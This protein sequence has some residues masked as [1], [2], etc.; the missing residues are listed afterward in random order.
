MQ[1]HRVK[2]G[3]DTLHGINAPEPIQQQRFAALDTKASPT[4]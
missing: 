1:R 4:R 2:V 3:R